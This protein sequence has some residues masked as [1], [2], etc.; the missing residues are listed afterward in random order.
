M[1]ENGEKMGEKAEKVVGKWEKL[2]ENV[3]MDKKWLEWMKMT[4]KC[5][6]LDGMQENGWKMG[7]SGRN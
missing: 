6:K 7:G 3:A 2:R 5:R 1:V 4:G